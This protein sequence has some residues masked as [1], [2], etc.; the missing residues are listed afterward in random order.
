M[1][2]YNYSPL[3]YEYIGS[4]EADIDPI[5]PDSFLIPAYATDIQPP[6]LSGKDKAIIFSNGVWTEV[7]DLR[8][9]TA[10]V[11]DENNFFT[12]LYN[13]QL[14]ETP[15]ETELMVEP[16]DANVY[17]PKWDGTKWIQGEETFT[18]CR[19]CIID[20]NC[21]FVNDFLFEEG[22][23]P[24]ATHILT[25]V[26]T[27]V[28]VPK[29]DGSKWV[30]GKVDYCGVS[31]CSI[32]EDGFF[33]KIISFVYA[34]EPDSTHIIADPPNPDEFIKPRWDGS[35]WVETASAEQLAEVAK[36]KNID[37]IKLQLATL[38]A[39]LPRCMEDLIETQGIDLTKL[40]QIMQDR[41]KS[42]QDLRA[43]LL[44]VSGSEQ[45]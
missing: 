38:D 41:L 39:V 31:G 36:Q 40:P 30:A 10:C 9:Y 35:K 3:T 42:K 24:D 37:D 17:K 25:N 11:V 7:V 1:I 18:G 32:D 12:G 20:E 19:G 43:Q 5:E 33:L 13:F 4:C 15:K 6:E 23:K 28:Y 22:Q 29:W 8:N 44:Y 14:G 16:P 26:P 21:F 45:T 27:G 34:E 2:L